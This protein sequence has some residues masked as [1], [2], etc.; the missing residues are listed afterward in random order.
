M[1]AL[2]QLL[3]PINYLRIKSSDGSKVVID[4]LV[5]AFIAIGICVGWLYYPSVIRLAGSGGLVE[6]VGALMQ[7]LV[8][9]YVA[10]LA[11]VA[12]FQSS[13]L[14]ENVIGMTLKGAP[15]KR[16]QFLA[17]LFGYLALLSLVLFVLMLFR[18][19]PAA[20]A[21]SL[22]GEWHTFVMFLFALAHQIVFWQMISVTLLGLHYL[23]DRIHRSNNDINP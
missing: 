20:A 9:F 10:S 13:S 4:W 15:I 14:D 22:T 11:A 1:Q 17:Y 8:G 18:G 3:T 5:P 7:V 12:T 16:R 21:S 19:V 23:A 2:R 6:S